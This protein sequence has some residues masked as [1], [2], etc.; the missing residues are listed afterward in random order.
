MPS[1]PGHLEE[2]RVAR[3]A[4]AAVDVARPEAAVVPVVERVDAER[5][6]ARRADLRARRDLLVGE[7]AG[8]GHELVG[9]A[10]RVVRLD[11]VVEQRLVR[12]R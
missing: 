2:E 12:V 5:E 9:R 4:E 11:R 8:A 3:V 10:G 6:V 7:R 1:L